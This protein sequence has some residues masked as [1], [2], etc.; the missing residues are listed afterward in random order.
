MIRLRVSGTWYLVLS[1]D[2]YLEWKRP[3]TLITHARNPF[4][5]VVGSTSL[6][7]GICRALEPVDLSLPLQQSAMGQEQVIFELQTVYV[8][9]YMQIG[10][11]GSASWCGFWT[12]ILDKSS[13][14][15]LQRA[16]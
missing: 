5:P 2:E 10:F 12:W 13:F 6:A 11:S 1:K 7:T 8:L 9:Y 15:F 14:C 3:G 16:S 4:K